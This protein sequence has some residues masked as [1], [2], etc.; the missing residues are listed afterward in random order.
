M[1]A[2]RQLEPHPAIVTGST[3]SW[4]SVLPEV[5]VSVLALVLKMGLE[6]GW[7]LFLTVLAA[8]GFQQ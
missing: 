2:L 6:R 8:F 7:G 4:Q 5:A 3:P 1:W